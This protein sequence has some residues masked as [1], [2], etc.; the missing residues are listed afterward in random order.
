MRQGN[1]ERAK[2]HLEEKKG[3]SALQLERSHQKG[4]DDEHM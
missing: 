2:S 4:W 1:H 3:L